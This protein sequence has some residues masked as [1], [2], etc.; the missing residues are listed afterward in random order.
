[1]LRV[2]VV[3]ATGYTGGELLRILFGHPFVEVTHVTSESSAGKPLRQAHGFLRRGP[4]LV[5][6]K[7]QAKKMA[8]DSDLA[9]FA[10]P[11]GVGS[12]AIADF[13][14]DELRKEGVRANHVEGF[15]SG[16]WVLVDYVDVVLHVFHSSTRAFYQL[17]ELWGDAER[18]E[19]QGPASR[20]G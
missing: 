17:E 18:K 3:G 8:R 16:R 1:M 7:Y 4:D 9:F 5:L 6:E 10:L 20:E 15:Q 11:H 12:K 14:I 19:Y 13:V 2:S